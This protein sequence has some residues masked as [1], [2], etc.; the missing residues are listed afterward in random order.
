MNLWASC[1]QA[2]EQTQSS[3][4]GFMDLYGEA[5]AQYGHPDHSAAIVA[6]NAPRLNDGRHLFIH[7]HTP[8]G[9][10]RRLPDDVRYFIILRDPV[11]RAVSFYFHVL[12]SFYEREGWGWRLKAGP[13]E[14][15]DIFH[16]NLAAAA[17]GENGA[18]PGSLAIGDVPFFNALRSLHKRGYKL[19]SAEA[20]A[21]F[22]EFTCT[23][24]FYMRYFGLFFGADAEYRNIYPADFPMDGSTVLWM[25][26]AI[27]RHF[28]AVCRSVDSAMRFAADCFALPV[29]PVGAHVNAGAYRIDGGDIERLRPYFKLDYQLCDAITRWRG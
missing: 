27:N 28:S 1:F 2:W 23:D 21:A 4:I 10:W 29:A 24:N 25:G 18:A 6:E 9:I 12:G 3:T 20:I 15:S 7:H 14:A 26:S 17:A 11:A 13:Q 16:R 22:L 8:F 5:L 19:D